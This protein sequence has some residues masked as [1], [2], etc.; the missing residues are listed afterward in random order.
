MENLEYSLTVRLPVK[1]EHADKFAK[2]LADTVRAMPQVPGCLHFSAG[3]S[4]ADPNVI[5][6][7]EIWVSKE[8]RERHHQSPTMQARMA[9]YP[10]LLV[11]APE[12][13]ELWLLG[14]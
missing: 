10:D 4:V 6:L 3:Q 11:G 12:V 9:T 13:T 8:D 14:I 7:F 1:P 2:E 5:I